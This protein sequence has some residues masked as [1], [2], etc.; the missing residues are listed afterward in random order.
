MA[1]RLSRAWIESRLSL[2]ERNELFE[3]ILEETSSPTGEQILGTTC[4]RL[5]KRRAK[6]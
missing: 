2:R 5:P 1:E 3:S 4:A 6:L